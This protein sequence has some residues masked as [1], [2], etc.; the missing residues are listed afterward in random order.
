MNLYTTMISFETAK[1]AL[2]KK[3]DW[4]CTEMYVMHNGEGALR[5]SHYGRTKNSDLDYDAV[6]AAC[7]QS[8]LHKWL[9]DT[10]ELVVN[11]YATAYG[12]L[13][14]I[15]KKDGT[16]LAYSDER[17]PNAGGAWD[18]YE[19][20]FESGLDAALKRLEV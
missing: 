3:F 12:Y 11:V 18:N 14:D 20:C 4:P 13:W 9:R 6:A 2:E 15:S 17:G 19:Q 16:W 10:H 8:V 1:L 7:S 5:D